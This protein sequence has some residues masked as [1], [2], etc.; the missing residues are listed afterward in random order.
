MNY[1][2][3]LVMA[4]MPLTLGELL[5]RFFGLQRELARKFVH[6]LGGL[7]AALLVLLFTSQEIMIVVIYTPIM[8]LV[9]KHLRSEI[10]SLYGVARTSYGEVVFP[11]G[12]GISAT[13]SPNE[14]RYIAAMLIL[15]ISDTLASLVGDRW[16]IWRVSIF[17]STRSLGGSGAFALSAF[18]ICLATGL[19]VNEAVSV[20]LAT[21]VIEALSIRGFDNATVPIIAVLA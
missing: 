14:E 19:G 9:R 18:V 10:K 17:S 20:A 16:P 6:V 5:T 2:L 3:V 15:G 13:F 8:I 12:V 11:L 21:T 7:V 4:G 1:I